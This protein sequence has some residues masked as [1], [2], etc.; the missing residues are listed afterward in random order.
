MGGD[1]LTGYN[2]VVLLKLDTTGLL[3]VDIDV[4]VLLA[5][6]LKLN[7]RTEVDVA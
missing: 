5:V 6:V 4:D 7:D 2:E 3:E 1:E